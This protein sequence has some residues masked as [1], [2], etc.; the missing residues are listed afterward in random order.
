MTKPKRPSV[1][2]RQTPVSGQKLGRSHRE[3]ER[4]MHDSWDDERESFPQFCMTC[5]K[6]FMPHDEKHLYCSDTYASNPP[7]PYHHC[8]H[9]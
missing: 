2:R 6:Q 3:R 9:C 5:E 4:E 8:A 7:S 1:A